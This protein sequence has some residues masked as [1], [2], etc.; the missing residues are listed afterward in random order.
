MKVLITGGAGFIG[1]HLVDELLASGHEVT[2][3]DNISTGKLEN[4]SHHEDDE[5]LAFIK[6]DVT[7]REEVRNSLKDVDS[8]IHAAAVTSVPLSVEKPELTENVNVEGTGIMLEESAEAEVK[9]FVYISSCA[10]YGKVDEVPINE[11]SDLNPISPYGESKLAAERKCLDF[12]EIHDIDPV[13]LR[14][15]NVYGPRQSFG[16]YAGVILKFFERIEENNPPIIFGDGEQT[17]DFVHVDDIVQGTLLALSR[18]GAE[19]EAINIGTGKAV[20][21]NEISEKILDV[22]GRR[23]LEPIYEKGKPGDIRHSRADIG[24]AR[25]ILDYEPRVSLEEGLKELAKELGLG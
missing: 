2:V 10:V 23:E 11:D 9:R 8:V 7:K 18:E 20:S 16:P 4:L 3:L 13:R 5:K 15:F 24:K 1:S 17:R 6:G 12:S 25:E 21:I 14:Y 22:T 19:G